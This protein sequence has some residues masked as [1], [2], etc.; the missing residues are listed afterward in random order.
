MA[1]EEKQ[2]R[3]CVRQDSAK[4]PANLR[5]LLDP[6]RT[7]LLNWSS[8]LNLSTAPATRLT[9]ERRTPR[10]VRAGPIP[11]SPQ[12]HLTHPSPHSRPGHRGHPRD[13]GRRRA[14]GPRHHHH[15]RHHHGRTPVTTVA[16]HTAVTLTATVTSSGDPVA[17]GAVNFCD[18]TVSYCTDIHRLGTAQ[19]TPSGTAVIK[20]ILGPGTHSI[21]AVFVGTTTATASA[22]AA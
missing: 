19:L 22:S 10:N 6:R 9:R 1:Q 17:P 4:F 15:P 13:A 7:F 12:I 5:F 3:P 21:K 2:N 11:H 18:A 16:Q 20:L 8:L 14:P